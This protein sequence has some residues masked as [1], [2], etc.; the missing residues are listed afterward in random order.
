[1]RSYR[2]LALFLSDIVERYECLTSEEILPQNRIQQAKF[3]YSLLEKALEKQVK[4]V[5]EQEEIQKN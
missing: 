1:M 2:V 3:T 4:A 5:E